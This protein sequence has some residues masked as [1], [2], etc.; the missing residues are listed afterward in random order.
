MIT[1]LRIRLDCDLDISTG[2]QSHFFPVFIL[3][4]VFDANLPVKVLGAFN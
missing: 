4:S 2:L 1:P 3:Q